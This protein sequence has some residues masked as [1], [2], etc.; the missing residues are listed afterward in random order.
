MGITPERVRQIEA[1]AF[2]KLRHSSRLKILSECI[3]LSDD[4][5]RDL[6][7]NDHSIPSSRLKIIFGLP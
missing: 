4:Y 5:L 7:T 3:D 6:K 2:R 1:K